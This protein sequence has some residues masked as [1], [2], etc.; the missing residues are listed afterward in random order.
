MDAWTKNFNQK[1]GREP[2]EEDIESD[3]EQS[4]R[5]R[6][7]SKLDAPQNDPNAANLDLNNDH[8]NHGKN[9]VFHIFSPH[10]RD[11]A[12]LKLKSELDAWESSFLNKYQRKPDQVDIERENAV[13]KRYALYQSLV[14]QQD[15][16][17]QN[18]K[19]VAHENPVVEQPQAYA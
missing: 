18:L 2:T 4:K 14:L 9:N 19:N 17:Q 3:K 15:Q 8:L 16:D 10:Q 11:L 5:T 1:N 12:V 6:L 7:Y 13:L